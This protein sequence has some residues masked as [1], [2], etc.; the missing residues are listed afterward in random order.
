MIGEK[1]SPI[2]P[3]PTPG[4]TRRMGPST[5]SVT[6]YT[7]RYTD[8][9]GESGEIGNQLRMTRTKMTTMYSWSSEEIG[10]EVTGAVGQER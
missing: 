4:I 6:A 2:P 1:S 3:K 7:N 5:G 10:C 8:A 9:I